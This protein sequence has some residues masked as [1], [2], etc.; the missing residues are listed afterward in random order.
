MAVTITSV[1]VIKDTRVQG[2]A[3]LVIGEHVWSDGQRWQVCFE[4]A[5]GADAIVRLQA[6]I[7]DRQDVRKAA[8]VARNISDVIANGSLASVTLNASTANDNMVGA[9]AV[10][11]SLSK[12][13]AIMMGDYFNTLTN[14]QLANLFG[15]TTGQ[16]STFRTNTLAPAASTAAAIRAAAGS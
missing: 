16:A 15:I 6:M 9:R 10:Y 4:A 11:P 12:T 3:G 14:A 2:Q 8:E 1:T 7:T 5:A 13:E